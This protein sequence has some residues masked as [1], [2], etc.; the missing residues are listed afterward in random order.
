MLYEW[1]ASTSVDQAVY[2]LSLSA[3][4]VV[5]WYEKFREVAASFVRRRLNTAV[6]GAGSTVEID[7]CQV[8]RRK[9]HRGRRPNEVWVFGGVVRDSAPFQMFLEIVENR[10]ATTLVP[11]IQ[12]RID[13]RSR[14][15]SDGWGAYG[16]L[17]ALGFSHAVINHS[18][19]FVS[20][21][22][23]SVHTQNIE[24]LWH[25]LRRFLNSRGSYARSHLESYLKEFI[26]RKA[27]VNPFETMISAIQESYHFSRTP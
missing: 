1:T 22:D 5:T 15:I 23:P 12:Q 27:F 8:G 9:Y 19:R 13:I 7:E 14:I 17:N 6:G 26:F 16:G 3:P 24:N 11:I 20:A 2:E 18:E 4:T 10:R 25:C 21:E